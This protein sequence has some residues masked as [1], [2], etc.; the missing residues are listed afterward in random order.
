MSFNHILTVLSSLS[1]GKPH[2]AEEKEEE[3][4]LDDFDFDG[5]EAF[6]KTQGV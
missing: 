4:G 1:L 5:M 2:L 6:A 3:D